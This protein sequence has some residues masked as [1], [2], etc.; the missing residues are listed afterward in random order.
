LAQLHGCYSHA[1]LFRTEAEQASAAT[2]ENLDVSLISLQAK[3]V[4]TSL[5]GFF[6][7]FAAE[8]AAY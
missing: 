3:R 7:G 5:N 8:L 4:Q 2:V 6:N 1:S